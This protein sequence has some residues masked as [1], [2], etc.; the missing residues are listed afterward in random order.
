[1]RRS[2]VGVAHTNRHSAITS[3]VQSAATRSSNRMPKPCAQPIGAPRRSL[4]RWSAQ[5]TGPGLAASKKRNRA[6]A[7]AWPQKRRGR[8][9]PEHE[10]EGDDLVPDDRRRIGL[11][12][13]ARG[14][15]AGPPAERARR[16]RGRRRA[17]RSSS[18]GAARRRRARR[19]SV[20][21]VPGATGDRPLPKPSATRCAGWATRKRQPGRAAG[22]G[23]AADAARA[24]RSWP[25]LG[26]QSGAEVVERAERAGHLR[27]AAV[28]EAQAAR[29]PRCGRCA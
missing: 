1:M 16:R 3:S 4:K 26:R 19:S 24:R 29:R 28:D 25:A 15:G 10:P 17:R 6:N 23:A 12:E 21:T 2:I 13:V 9:Q 7:T 27:A 8:D 5:A 22:A 11:R 20:P 14:H 18:S